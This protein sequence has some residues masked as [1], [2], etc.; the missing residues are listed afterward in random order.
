MRGSAGDLQQLDV[1]DAGGRSVGKNF[2]FARRDVEPDAANAVN[3]QHASAVLVNVPV[4]LPVTAPTDALKP[5]V[6]TVPPD[7]L[8]ITLREEL[9]EPDVI[10]S[11]PPPKFK[12]PVR[13]EAAVGGN[14]QHAAVEEHATGEF[15]GVI[16]DRGAGAVL[17]ERAEPAD[18][19]AGK[20]VRAGRVGN[21]G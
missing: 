15:V 6:S 19:T 13:P 14:G 20:H 2:H 7:A 8:T 21:R 3:R 16:E 1:A 11:V 9:N 4:P 10:R 12:A 5:A 18:R 17:G